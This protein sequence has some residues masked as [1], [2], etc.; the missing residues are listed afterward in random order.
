MQ[1]FSKFP[2]ILGRFWQKMR[3]GCSFQQ[4]R[5]YNTAPNSIFLPPWLRIAPGLQK[6][7][8]C[9]AFQRQIIAFLRKKSTCA[10]KSVV[11][12]LTGRFFLQRSISEE[13]KILTGRFFLQTS[14]LLLLR[15]SANEKRPPRNT[16]R[17]PFFIITNQIKI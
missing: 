10:G 13:A 4:K 7:S 17:W 15:V 3:V 12:I 11:K 16:P 8:T 6:K 1:L 2:E 14:P 9:A 5:R